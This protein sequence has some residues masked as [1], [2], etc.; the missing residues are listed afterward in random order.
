MDGKSIT[1]L[2][3]LALIALLIRASMSFF[4]YPIKIRITL[5]IV[6]VCLVFGI[7]FF[8]ASKCFR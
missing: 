7:S 2:I 3:G 8:I 1:V 4:K 5:A 6:S